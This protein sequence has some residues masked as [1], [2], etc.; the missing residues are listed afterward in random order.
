M[1]LPKLATDMITSN[2]TGNFVA[3]FSSWKKFQG[4]FE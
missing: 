3:Y 4:I 1:R 2:F